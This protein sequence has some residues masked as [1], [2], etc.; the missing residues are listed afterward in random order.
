[1]MEV[2][3]DH[4]ELV[5]DPD[6]YNVYGQYLPS[7]DKQAKEM[8]AASVLSGIVAVAFMLLIIL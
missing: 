6:A 4:E 5:V 8:V 7:D 3:H 1:M 2:V